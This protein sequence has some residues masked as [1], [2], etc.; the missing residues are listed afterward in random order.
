MKS[1]IPSDK[2]NL[3]LE[4]TDFIQQVINYDSPPPIPPSL[5]SVENLGTLYQS[6]VVLREALYALAKG[7][8]SIQ[9]S[10]K[11]YIGGA[12]KTLQG[13]LRHLTW[14]TKMVASGDFSQRVD[15]MG[16]FSQSFNA[17]V[18]QLDQTINE[19]MQKEKELKEANRQ[20]MDE[21][22]VRKKTEEALRES[23]EALRRLAITDPLTG[24]FNRRHL[25]HIAEAEL[26]KAIRYQRSLSVMIL[27]IDF[28][29]RIN[30]QYG[31]TVGDR[32]IQQTAFLIK[33]MIRN[34]DIPSRYGGEEFLVLLPETTAKEA[35]SVAERLRT[36]LEHTPLRIK[37]SSIQATVS[38]GI[39]EFRREQSSDSSI[40]NTWSGLIEKSD[41]ALYISKRAGR[42]QV[43][44]L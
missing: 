40:E 37:G 32:V 25:N 31:H 12:L 36:A 44:V 7:D 43:T 14:Q 20:L 19:L 11:G 24:L 27:D 3:L 22:A 6:L 5:A 1:A 29:K 38:I 41:Q 33:K 42:N 15:F 35:R 30:D 21:I 8:L 13:N 16:D 23:E 10:L 9:I 4:L 17:M 18:I 2:H 26:R 28:F 34:T 39:S